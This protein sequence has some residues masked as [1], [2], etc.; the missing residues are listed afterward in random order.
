VI[1]RLGPSPLPESHFETGH[2]PSSFIKPFSAFVVSAMGYG[3]TMIS[4]DLSKM[5]IEKE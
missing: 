5:T 4:R 3:M 1:E 2:H